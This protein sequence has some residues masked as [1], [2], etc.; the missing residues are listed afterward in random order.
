ML[1]DLRTRF[2]FGYGNGRNISRNACIKGADPEHFKAGLIP[3]IYP[4]YS[5][6][7]V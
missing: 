4:N 7:N 3:D 6:R 5:D 2:I 1:C